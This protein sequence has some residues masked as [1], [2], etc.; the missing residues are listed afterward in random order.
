MSLTRAFMFS[1]AQ[2]VIVSLWDV[3]DAATAFLM[4]TFY[5]LW[6]AGMETSQ[7]LRAAQLAVRD[8]AV[9]ASIEEPGQPARKQVRHPWK[10]ER[11]WAA[12]TLWGLGS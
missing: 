6:S 5:R 12:W 8:H 10:D 2:R 4:E 3:D 9:E 1:G 7:A 11:Y